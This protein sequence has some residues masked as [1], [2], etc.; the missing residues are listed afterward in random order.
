MDRAVF[1]SSSTSTSERLRSVLRPAG[2]FFAGAAA[3]LVALELALRL[4][5]VSVGLYQTEQVEARPLRTYQAHLPFTYS[6]TW[7]MRDVRHGWTNNYGQLAPFD[8]VPGSRPV[9]V[10]GDSYIESQMN[11]YRDTL[12]GYLGNM[13]RAREPVYGL[14]VSGMSMADYLA[15]AHQ[16]SAEF[17]PRAAVFLVVDGDTSGS[18]IDQPGY[19]YFR[20]TADGLKLTLHRGSLHPL[21]RRVRQSMGDIYLFRYA[22]RNLRFTFPALGSV[23]REAKAGVAAPTDREAAEQYA[24]IDRFLADLPGQSGIEPHCVAF[25]LDADR[26]AIY[27]PRLASATLDLPQARAY[28]MRRAAELGYRVADLEPL[29]RAHFKRYRRHF[30]YYPFDRHLNSLGHRLAAEQAY[31]LFDG[32]RCL[33][34]AAVDARSRVDFASRGRP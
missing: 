4:F 17:A 11:D 12:Q 1:P 2:L 9:I 32:G 33:G 28:L 14:G 6:M 8:Y 18:L 34:G 24:V 22:T 20:Q 29:F 26:Y 25:L 3:T 31:D 30:D 27:D 16:A 19:H 21:L 10:V 5:P 7:E 13:L 15:L 23:F